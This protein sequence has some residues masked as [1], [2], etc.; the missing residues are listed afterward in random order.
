M[1]SISM[2]KVSATTMK[3]LFKPQALNGFW[4]PRKEFSKQNEILLVVTSRTTKIAAFKIFWE[5]MRRLHC[6]AYQ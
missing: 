5:S 2:E 3:H 4:N 1:P 6:K